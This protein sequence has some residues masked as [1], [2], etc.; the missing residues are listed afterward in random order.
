[1]T[2]IGEVVDFEFPTQTIIIP[3]LK[4]RALSIIARP[5]KQEDDPSYKLIAGKSLDDELELD[6]RIA[7]VI[8]EMLPESMHPQFFKSYDHVRTPFRFVD[9]PFHRGLPDR[10]PVLQDEETMQSYP[11][12]GI[13]EAYLVD[14]ENR[15][16]ESLDD[17][18]KIKLV[19]FFVPYSFTA[20]DGS[21]NYNEGL[22]TKVDFDNL[23]GGK[24]LKT[25]IEGNEA[26]GTDTS[27]FV[28]FDPKGNY[29]EQMEQAG[30]YFFDLSVGAYELRVQ[31]CGVQTDGTGPEQW[32]TEQFIGD[33]AQ[34]QAGAKPQLG[35]LPALMYQSG[36]EITVPKL[37]LKELRLL[38]KKPDT[39]DGPS[40]D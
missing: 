36:L 28:A 39:L 25:Q 1:M 3:D 5:W 7:E 34:H 23:N 33:L 37:T 22:V 10:E 29:K 24:P 32:A 40:V 21:I 8:L 20:A 6:Y 11:A 31:N 14:D 35:N 2:N 27:I 9:A 16:V 19:S 26:V 18:R 12:A 4:E 38:D 30:G 15:R 17:V 13:T